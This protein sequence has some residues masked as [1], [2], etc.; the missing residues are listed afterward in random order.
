MKINDK[1]PVEPYFKNYNK[2]VHLFIYLFIQKLY[3]FFECNNVGLK[4]LSSF[5]WTD[6]W[7]ICLPKCHVSFKVRTQLWTALF[8]FWSRLN[9]TALVRV[10]CIIIILLSSCLSK[11]D[12]KSVT[13]VYY[14]YYWL[15]GPHLSCFLCNNFSET[16][17]LL[18]P[19]VRSL[20]EERGGVE[21]WTCF[22]QKQDGG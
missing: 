11:W 18:C 6:K 10:C 14:Y 15:L 19:Q 7:L 8:I 12:A 21:S 9:V 3:L 1:I 17:L 4:I 16:G 22:K 2:T 20:H 13:M 5:A